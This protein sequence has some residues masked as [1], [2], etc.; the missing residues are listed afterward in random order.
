M[1]QQMQMQ[2][3]DGYGE[4][5]DQAWNGDYSNAQPWEQSGGDQ[6]WGQGEQQESWEESEQQ[7]SSGIDSLMHGSSFG[8]R[9]S[10]F[11]ATPSASSPGDIVSGANA[12]SHRAAEGGDHNDDV[13]DDDDYDD[14]AGLPM[15]EASKRRRLIFSNVRHDRLEAVEAVL[16]AGEFDIDEQD[17]NGISFG[18]ESL[19]NAL[20]LK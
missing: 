16:S 18:D 10:P 8:P 1:Q 3:Q 2:M 17:E 13:D 6:S 5:G 7:T 12:S 9:P 11:R 15:D 4:S 14:D 19:I 20:S